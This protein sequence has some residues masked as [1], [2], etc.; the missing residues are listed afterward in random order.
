ME[1]KNVE[2]AIADVP[3]K[4]CRTYPLSEMESIVKQCAEKKTLFGELGMPKEY[5]GIDLQRVSHEIT[6]VH[7]DGGV[8]RAN[9]KVLETPMG[10]VLKEI[11]S[12]GASVDYRLSGLGNL[13]KDGLVTDF[14]FISINAVNDGA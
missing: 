8:L 13:S 1:Q 9:I 10:K 2:V 3:N 4:N 14:Q 6:N 11:L 12:S 7:L 5:R